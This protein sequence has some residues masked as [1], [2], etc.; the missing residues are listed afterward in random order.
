MQCVEFGLIWMKGNKRSVP[1]KNE[2]RNGGEFCI[3]D[4]RLP[5]GRTSVSQDT[6]LFVLSRSVTGANLVFLRQSLAR[7]GAIGVRL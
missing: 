4:G 5:V 3:Q 7:F 1:L 6:F 2:N